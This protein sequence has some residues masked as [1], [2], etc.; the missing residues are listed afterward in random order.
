MFCPKCGTQ[1][2]KNAQF[3]E[4]CG[5][6]MDSGVEKP[7][8]RPYAQNSSG[9]SSNDKNPVSGTV[10]ILIGVII[11]L[12]SVFGA[13]II[14]GTDVFA[15]EAISE[16]GAVNIVNNIVNNTTNNYP[17]EAKNFVVSKPT[18]VKQNGKTVWQVPVKYI[19]TNP[20]I[21]SV[22]NGKSVFIPTRGTKDANGQ[23]Q[24]T[25]TL[26]NG[27]TIDISSNTQGVG[28]IVIVTP[29]VL[30]EAPPTTET[31]TATETATQTPTQGTETKSS[32]AH[33]ET[34]IDYDV[35]GDGTTEDWELVY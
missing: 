32:S 22:F 5:Y 27:A 7:V 21:A 23:I 26:P 10:F 18:K 33:K 1:N 25:L 14:F 11:L 35:D 8:K 16:E 9:H 31:T 34:G 3:C 20:N 28:T 4:S 6:R 29:G 13:Y 19:G 2:Q 12:V 24:V 30:P 17:G 15:Q